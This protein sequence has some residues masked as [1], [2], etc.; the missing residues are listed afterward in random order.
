[1][2]KRVQFL[3]LVAAFAWIAVNA[4]AQT[5]S[6]AVSSRSA[7]SAA[8]VGSTIN[9]DGDVAA[10]RQ[11]TPGGEVIW[12]K[13]RESIDNAGH[14][15][16]FARQ[17]LRL[18]GGDVEIFGS[19]I[20]MHYGADGK[21]SA[22]LGTQ[23]R[24][25]HIANKLRLSSSDVQQVAAAKLTG[26][27]SKRSLG[28]AMLPS[29]EITGHKP[30]VLLAIPSGNDLRF[31]YQ[32]A[33]SDENGRSIET[34]IDA[35]SE[36]IL[37]ASDSAQF[38]N[39]GPSLPKT[40]V[41][42]FGTPQR[43]DVPHPA[44]QN[45]YLGRGLAA[46]ATSERGT[47]FPYEAFVPGYWNTSPDMYIFQ[48]IPPYTNLGFRC[49][50][51]RLEYPGYTLFP[52]KADSGYA[53]AWGYGRFDDY[54]PTG[55]GWHGSAA[56]DALHKTWQTV[57]AFSDLGR[58]GF[59]GYWGP[60]QVVIDA[61][62]I[63]FPDSTAYFWNTS[64]TTQNPGGPTVYI[65]TP[66]YNSTLYYSSASLD[67]IAHEWGHG[68]I[69][70]TAGFSTTTCVPHT[71]C[72]GTQLSEGFAD[73]FGQL[74]EKMYEPLGSGPETSSD[75]DLAEDVSKIGQYAFSGNRDDGSGHY[76]GNF[77]MFDNKLHRLDGADP[78]NDHDRGNM[79]N[80]VYYLLS[81]GGANPACTRLYNC[82]TT[83]PTGLGSYGAGKLLFDTLQFYLPSTTTWDTLPNYANFATFDLYSRC[84][85]TPK[86]DA[87]DKQESV[88]KAFEA[89]G[90]ATTNANRTCP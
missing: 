79:L 3:A 45:P 80:V 19:E 86:Y 33:V 68:V 44:Y 89:I 14:R 76:Y 59:D 38:G 48:E 54:D 18:P 61:S 85:T 43:S 90:Y 65:T 13:V 84:S 11:V 9:V 55:G 64:A 51:T 88:R 60:M 21:L 46:N 28:R 75:W 83:V 62:M 69:N 49:D 58:H 8:L 29:A 57:S 7:L 77:P 34:L 4:F 39:C 53:Q 26:G 78:A 82:G 12:K 25:F 74:V 5:E 35:D 10:A 16:V 23:F 32:V 22:A 63:S 40:M 15:H 67:Q 81:E 27:L 36:A 20:G 87:A 37:H 73:V 41:G 47:D 70:S 1:M 52:V 71:P 31:A 66:P 6:V 2:K 24:S 42:A 72:V 56:G 50:S 17:Y 30:A